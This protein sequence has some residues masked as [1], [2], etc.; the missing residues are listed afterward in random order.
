MRL[1]VLVVMLTLLT[2]SAL[3]Q[4]PDAVQISGQ[5]IDQST[6]A[7]LEGIGFIG[8]RTFGPNFDPENP[9]DLALEQGGLLSLAPYRSGRLP[10]VLVHGTA[11][12][13]GRWAD[14]VNDLSSDPV[15]RRNFH[16]LL[17]SYNTGNPI[18]YS[19]WLL[20]EALEGFIGAVGAL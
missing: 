1:L 11:S 8:G 14:L 19:G 7:P 20:R 10:V 13:A 18:A 16:L 9:G 15:I 5:V 12:S 2:G 17:F 3:S 6:V 4:P